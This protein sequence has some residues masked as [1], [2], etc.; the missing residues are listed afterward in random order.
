MTPKC[1]LNIVQKYRNIAQYSPILK[2]LRK[3]EL[4]YSILVFKS[5][6]TIADHQPGIG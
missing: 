6:E 1:N 3:R 4:Q 2:L 5:Q